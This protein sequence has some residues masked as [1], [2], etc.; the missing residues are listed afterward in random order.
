VSQRAGL[1]RGRGGIHRVGNRSA[2]TP[3][4]RSSGCLGRKR[5]LERV[6]RLARGRADAPFEG[7]QGIAFVAVFPITF[8]ASTFVPTATLPGVLR[9]FAEW[10]PVTA[11]AGALRGR[12]GNPGGVAAPDASWPLRHAIL[13]TLIWVVGP[14][15]RLRAAG[16]SRLSA[17]D[18]GLTGAALR[19]AVAI[20]ASSATA[21][22]PITAALYSRAVGS[23]P[24]PWTT[25]TP[26]STA[27]SPIA[28]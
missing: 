20:A 23:R 24:A 27:G 3:R 14:C 2:R 17:L 10:N 6:E 25:S 21:E 12:S 7:V 1:Q 13:Y 16:R 26:P 18:Q 5:A 22:S 19:R 28:T 11:L 8:I 4:G 9:T 15:R